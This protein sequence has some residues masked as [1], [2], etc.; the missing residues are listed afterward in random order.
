M[1]KQ[2]QRKR[3]WLVRCIGIHAYEFVESVGVPWLSCGHYSDCWEVT[4]SDGWF[5]SM[6]SEHFDRIFPHLK[7]AEGEC[8]EIEIREVVR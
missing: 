6:G 2:P 7:L 5:S 1:K 3:L 4:R 8:C